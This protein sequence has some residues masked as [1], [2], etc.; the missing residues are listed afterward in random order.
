MVSSG[1][2][3]GRDAP[4]EAVNFFDLKGVVEALLSGLQIPDVNFRRERLPAYLCQ[5]ARVFAGDL[6]L[7]FLGEVEPEVGD[8]LDLEGAIFV[9]NLAFEALAQATAPPLF[10]A[11]PRYPAVYRDLALV[12]D[13]ELPA[14]Q[15]TEA[16]YRHGQPWLVEARLFDVYTGD[17]V[18]AGKRSLAFRLS[19]RDPEGTLTDEKI[20]PH[21]QALVQALA[22][23][24]GAE[25]R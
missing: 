21:H 2:R 4:R 25:L 3:P 5:G 8:Q 20:N 11:L 16:L 19:Y 17:Q 14:A 24:L 22:R 15:V 9:F 7:G 6:E 1:L 18:P 12:L 13:K 23:E 10:T